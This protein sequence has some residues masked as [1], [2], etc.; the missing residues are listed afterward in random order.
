MSLEM[1]LDVAAFRGGRGEC[2]GSN[3]SGISRD[4]SPIDVFQNVLNI[5]GT[6]QYG[7][8]GE[9]HA[10]WVVHNQVGE[11]APELYGPVR[12]VLASVADFGPLGQLL[13]CLLQGTPD[14]NL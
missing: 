8:N 14:V 12:Q 7:N 2:P 13:E 10:G 11:D 3:P 6:V 4:T 9:R 5:S 1:S